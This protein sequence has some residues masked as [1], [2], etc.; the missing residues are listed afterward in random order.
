MNFI[1]AKS[2]NP[3]DYD[4]NS[5]I[6][7]ELYG[8]EY[9]FYC[10]FFIKNELLEFFNKIELRD[11]DDYWCPIFLKDWKYYI[12]HKA[13]YSKL[14]CFSDLVDFD[15]EFNIDGEIFKPH[16]PYII[17]EFLNKLNNNIPKLS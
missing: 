9:K 13:E 1:L 11:I 7:N 10:G 16:D 14:I 2:E 3:N 17:D 15:A 12:D 6:D 4:N 5:M 8:G